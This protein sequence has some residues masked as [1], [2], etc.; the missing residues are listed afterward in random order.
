MALLLQRLLNVVRHPM[1]FLR[2]DDK[3][4]VRYFLEQRGAASLG[5]A[6]EKAE[7]NLR[8]LF[9]HSAEHSHFAECLLIGHV[10][11]AAGVEQNYICI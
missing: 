7:N 9:R 6:T 3:I 4:Q 2:A 8:P 10:A 5:H 1:K 11:Y